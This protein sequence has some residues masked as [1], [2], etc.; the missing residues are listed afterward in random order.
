V[1]CNDDDHDNVYS[2]LGLFLKGGVTYDINVARVSDSSVDSI[3][4]AL[5]NTV[6]V[7]NTTVI[8]TND[9]VVDAIHINSPLPYTYTQGTLHA[10]DE[11][12]EAYP[13]CA[14]S[15][16]ASVWYQYTPSVP[17]TVS[18]STLGS[19]YDTVLSIWMGEGYPT[20][21]IGCN[22]DAVT[23]NEQEL[24]SQLGV[25]LDA[26]I[27][28]FIK[29]G[30]SQG[31]SGHL[32]LNVDHTVNDLNIT[33]QPL[34]KT[35]DKGQST[36]LTIRVTGTMPLSYQWYE[37]YQGDISAPRVNT[38]TFTTPALHR[39]T[40]YWV[41]VTNSTGHIDSRTVVIH[42]NGATNGVGVNAQG[43]PIETTA[44]FV[45]TIMTESGLKGND[46]VLTREDSATVTMKIEAEKEHADES[47]TLLIFAYYDDGKTGRSAY[48]LRE[49]GGWE[50]WSG[51]LIDLV[52]AQT[53]LDLK[54]SQTLTLFQGSLADVLPGTTSIYV[55]YRSSEGDVI[56]SS[57]PI[58]FHLE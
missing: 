53:T 12:V 46:L 31:K 58:R 18:L 41:R 48:M 10:T 25:S 17:E 54:Q 50:I 47:V 32:V 1:T 3:H 14:P 19:D 51:H 22:D 26:G 9:D 45:G 21:E 13:S 23:G 40:R 38:E 29:V 44:H 20:I 30:R 6:L 5:D 36:T 34:D 28:Y 7:L 4:N 15:S 2:Q 35:I 43:S 55:G 42:V 8:P 39:T 56:Y 57:E 27:T 11:L 24:T 33:T 49:E 52:A 16:R 37:G